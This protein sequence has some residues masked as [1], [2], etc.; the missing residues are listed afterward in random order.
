M[1]QTVPRLVDHLFRHEAG[2]LSAALVRVLGPANLDLAE[3]VVQET[4]C[5]ALEVWKMGRVPDNPAAWLRTSARNRALDL[6]R[7]LRTRTR[8]LPEL[9]LLQDDVAPAVDA[10]FTEDALREEQ[11]RMMFACCDARLQPAVQVA[12]VLKL[13]CGF[14]VGEVAQAFLASPA[15]IEKRLLRGKAALRRILPV[16]GFVS[17]RLGIRFQMTKPEMMKKSCT[18]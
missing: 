1:T 13:L 15:A 11:L 4:L 2:R 18:A 16:D 14:S 5:H 8:L 17:P 10:A 3:D 7:R 6:L 12:L 9:S